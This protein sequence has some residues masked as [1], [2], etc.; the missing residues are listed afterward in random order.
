MSYLLH[1][2]EALGVRDD[3]GG[4]QSLLKVLEELLLVTL[5]LG[6]AADE[7]RDLRRPGYAHP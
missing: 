6:D 3:L 5:E 4:I 2:H 7:L 1:Q